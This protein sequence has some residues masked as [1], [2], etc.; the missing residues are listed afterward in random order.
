[1]RIREIENTFAAENNEALQAATRI[2]GEM[3]DEL[4]LV[5]FVGSRSRSKIIRVATLA[6]ETH[7]VDGIDQA[8]QVLAVGIRPEDP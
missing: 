4:P 2:G 3:M 6:D 7:G 1:M 8:F 5:S